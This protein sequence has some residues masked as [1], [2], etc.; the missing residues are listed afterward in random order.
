VHSGTPPANPGEL[1]GSSLMHDA[2]IAAAQVFDFIVIDTPPL[3]SVTDP[4]IVAPMTDGVILVT[5]GAKNPPEILKRAKKSL[6]LVHARIL[7]VLCNNVDLHSNSYHY[8]YH[9]YAE[10]SSYVSEDD[11][12][13]SA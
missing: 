6:D 4:L 8:Y 13:P 12:R 5:K 2:M 11:Q 3:M 7:G 10:Y 1:L 9:Q